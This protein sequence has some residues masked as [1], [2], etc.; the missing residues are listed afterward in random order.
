VRQVSGEAL[1][2]VDLGRG[3]FE[4]DT[5]LGTVAVTGTLFRVSLEE[6]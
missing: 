1:Y 4:V 5:P 3:P 6:H 2:E